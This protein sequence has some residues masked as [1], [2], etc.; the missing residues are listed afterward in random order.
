MTFKNPYKREFRIK[1]IRYVNYRVA[2]VGKIAIS[3]P[4]QSCSEEMVSCSE[5]SN[6]PFR[7]LH[8][9][10]SENAL[11]KPQLCII[12]LIAVLNVFW[13]AVPCHLECCSS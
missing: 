5:L 6:Q 11:A 13:T 7:R 8:F 4:V 3:S 10:R 9:H 1:A 2:L 12:R